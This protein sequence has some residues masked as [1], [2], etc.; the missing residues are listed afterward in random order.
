MLFCE[1]Y[2]KNAS[3]FNMAAMEQTENCDVQENKH[4][5]SFALSAKGERIMMNKNK[6]QGLSQKTAE[7]IGLPR[8]YSDGKTIKSTRNRSASVG[9]IVNA[10]FHVVLCPVRGG[11]K[12]QIFTMTLLLSLG[13]YRTL[14]YTFKRNKDIVGFLNQIKKRM[15][16]ISPRDLQGLGILVYLNDNRSKIDFIGVNPWIL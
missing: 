9:T 10:Y 14:T 1:E 12:K 15:N 13:Q 11:K 7:K 4:K 6:K 5:Q 16:W 3:A 2:R 8:W